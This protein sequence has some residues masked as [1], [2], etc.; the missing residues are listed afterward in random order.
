MRVLR[1]DAL[2]TFTAVSLLSDPGHSPGQHPIPQ[3]MEITIGWTQDD[4]VKASNVLH[5]RYVGVYPGSIGM[6]QTLLNAFQTTYNASIIGFQATTGSLDTVSLRDLNAISQPEIIATLTPVAGAG[7]GTPLP[8]E[9]A[10]VMTEISDIASRSGRGRIY[11]PNWD[12]GALGAGNV[13]NSGAVTALQTFGT[14]IRSDINAV[15]N[16]F[17]CLALPPRLAYTGV[18]GAAHP[19]RDAGTVDVTS[20]V[21]RDNHWDSQRRRG[22]K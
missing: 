18:S 12:S 8:C 19:A 14:G 20:V 17:M 11:V 10:A 5:A 2:D 1:L 13:I 9:V 7:T 21:V 3:C 4:A 16:L 6:A 15:A 22:L